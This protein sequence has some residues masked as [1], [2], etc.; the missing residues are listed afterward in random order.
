MN[1]RRAFWLTALL[2]LPA[3]CSAD[4][5]GDRAVAG[6]K[7]VAPAKETSPA[8]NGAAAAS[9]TAQ[10]E[11]AAATAASAECPYATRNFRAGWYPAQAPNTGHQLEIDWES[12]PDAQRRY[13][14]LNTIEQTPLVVIELL[15]GTSATPPEFPADWMES[16][17]SVFSNV[18][19]THVV[20]R[21]G[22]REI[23][24]VAIPP[25]P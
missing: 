10:S 21:C 6:N 19:N 7:A 22:G 23:A 8:A 9:G 18:A 11:I 17:S 13:A 2:T 25:R 14:E 1:R 4:G 16:R 24:R 20:L 15:P 12:M 3:A 5:E